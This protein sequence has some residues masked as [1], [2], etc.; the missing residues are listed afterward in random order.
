MILCFEIF[1]NLLTLAQMCVCV[2]LRA[3]WR[4]VSALVI[5]MH[6]FLAI[7]WKLVACVHRR[8]CAYFVIVVCFIYIL[9]LF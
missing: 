2:C 9:Y 5:Y 1:Y 6:L 4:V 8:V 7:S 3:R